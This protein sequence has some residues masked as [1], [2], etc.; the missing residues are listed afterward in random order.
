M[1]TSPTKLLRLPTVLEY[2]DLSRSS[3]YLR[4]NQRLWPKPV[5]LG[6]RAV[7]WPE[8]EVAEIINARVAGK[9]NAE[10]KS[11]IVKLETNRINR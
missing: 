8:N 5:S 9:S 3:L 6:S 4:I 10:I 2:S 7:A 11:I 1:P